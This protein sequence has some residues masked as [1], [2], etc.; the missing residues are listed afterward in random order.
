MRMHFL[1]IAF[2]LLRS[3]T[4]VADEPFALVADGKST[5]VLQ[6]TGNKTV[7]ADSAFF[8]EGLRR[9]T[10]GGIEVEKRGGGGE[11]TGNRILFEIEKRSITEEDRY[12]ISFPDEKTMRIVGSETSCRW[13]LN[14]LLEEQGVV[15][16]AAGP[17]GTHWPAKRDVVVSRVRRT[18]PASM[19]RLERDLY[20]EDSAWLRSN[21]GKKQKS[22]FFWHNLGELFPIA[23]Y[24]KE[25]WLSKLMPEKKG[26]R[27]C[28]TDR[29]LAWQ[30]CFSSPE[31]VDEA[32]RLVCE[33]LDRH[34]E[35]KTYSLAVNDEDGY[36]ECEGCRKLNGGS[37]EKSVYLPVCRNFSPVYYAWVNKVAKGVA[38]R[39][40]NVV[41]GLLSYLCV[42]D[43]P[44][45][46]L[47]DNV[48]PYVCFDIQQLSD[49]KARANR[50]ALLK[51]WNEKA[52]HVGIWDYSFGCPYAACFREYPKEQADFFAMKKSVC[53]ALDGF[54][55]EGVGTYFASEWR[56]RYLYLRLAFDTTRDPALE[57]DRW[58][59]ACV[60]EA[61]ADDLKAY[62]GVW[63]DFYRSPALK[64]TRWYEQ[65]STMTYYGIHDKDYLFAL[66]EATRRRADE[67]MTSVLAK[68]ESAGT[69]DQKIRARK[70]KNMHD[71]FAVWQVACGCGIATPRGEMTAATAER[72]LSA[73]P[74]IRSAEAA[75]PVRL[76]RVFADA[77]ECGSEP[78]EGRIRHFS[79]V[80]L[81]ENR[82][83][84]M[85]GALKYVGAERL[86]AA[87][88]LT[89]SATNQA[90][91]YLAAWR[92][93]R[94][95]LDVE[96]TD[97]A[98]GTPRFALTANEQRWKAAMNCV[99]NVVPGGTYC[100]SARIANPTD[101]E[102]NAEVGLNSAIAP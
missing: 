45:F 60:G 48:V 72:Y 57:L 76:E 70:L 30:P 95:G 27:T 16:C 7:D 56:R 93:L 36:C 75:A 6:L 62:Y 23:K 59:R 3:A 14:R 52:K 13:A 79:R 17:H 98:D 77:R 102:I 10:G 55:T 89:V 82:S 41:I 11:W 35:H 33:F 73:L 54:F 15:F 94:R 46:R 42:I 53:P 84:L 66:D 80:S 38:K 68:T 18:S 64:S 44:P 22:R 29:L 47:E 71:Y 65:G 24:G 86:C 78:V 26:R 4:G 1:I 63:E 40:P 67:L 5:C 81:N 39:H 91:P 43:P 49:P 34:P 20:V 32:I 31:G 99:T 83:V 92:L 100:V 8:V 9:I 87:A 69:E 96:A 101:H 58:Y 50:T 74:D 51:A 28:P 12:E 19:I 37:F 97:S 61:A 90:D 85:N 21:G 2:C 25:P 88:G